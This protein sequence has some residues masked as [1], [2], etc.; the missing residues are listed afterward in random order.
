MEDIIKSNP[1]FVIKTH[2]EQSPN[3]NLL[4]LDVYSDNRI[5]I[6]KDIDA[7]LQPGFENADAVIEL[8]NYIE[9]N[10]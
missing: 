2:I 10:K 5:F 7:F 4:L 9:N 3:K 6:P 8:Y 1:D